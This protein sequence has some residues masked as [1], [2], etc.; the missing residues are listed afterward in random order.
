MPNGKHFKAANTV[1][2]PCMVRNGFFPD[3]YSF[4]IVIG[5]TPDQHVIIG[6][7]SSNS[8]VQ[9]NGSKFVPALIMES[10]EKHSAR[11][12]L[13]GELV[14]DTNPVTVPIGWLN[15]FL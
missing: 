12:F 2:L 11:I 9:K 5:G 1:L 13:P 4:R 3:E 6:N 15:Q 10:L 7:V 14:S 8:I